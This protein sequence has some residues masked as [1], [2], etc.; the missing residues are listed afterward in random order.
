MG[1]STRNTWLVGLMTASALVLGGAASGQSPCANMGCA[2]TSP[3]PPPPPPGCCGDLP[4]GQTVSLPNVHIGGA[5]I[6]VSTPTVSVQ[7]GQMRYSSSSSYGYSSYASGQREVTTYLSGGGA[8]FASEGVAPTTLSNLN[9]TG[10]EERY[11]ETIEEQVPVREEI[12]V[13][14]ENPIIETIVPIRA[15]CLDDTGT[16][17][18]A[19]QVTGDQRIAN[20]YDGEIYRCMAGTSMQ[21][22]VGQ[23]EGQ[24][25]DFS[26]GES[27][28]CQKGEALVR[29]ANGELSCAPQIPQRDCNERSLLRQY[30]PGVKLVRTTARAECVPQTRTRMETRIRQVERVRA[31]APVTGSIVLDGGV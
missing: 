13:E 22:T 20:G 17:H 2:G 31:A 23:L 7:H 28:S 18:P 9:V 26:Q 11:M 19:S 12:C 1:V 10:A 25:A 24:M 21:V 27:F 8:Y 3:P 5:S 15:V 29:R 14:P 30:G 6:S 16:P 4:R